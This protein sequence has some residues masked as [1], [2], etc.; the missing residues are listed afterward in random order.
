MTDS[1]AP[2]NHSQAKRLF[3]THNP[4]GANCSFLIPIFIE[5]PR[6]S[7][8]LQTLSSDVS[9]VIDFEALAA[10]PPSI[11]MTTLAVEVS[12]GQP[13]IH[14]FR[15]AQNVLIGT[16]PELMAS[17][18]KFVDEPDLIGLP[19]LRLSVV[20]FCGLEGR[21]KNASANAYDYFRLISDYSAIFWRDQTYLTSQAQ[22]ILWTYLE[23][24]NYPAND[25]ALISESVTFT[26]NRGKPK[27]SIGETAYQA[28]NQFTVGSWQSRINE[29]LKKYL[30]AF[31]IQDTS[32]LFEVVTI[33]DVQPFANV[34][35]QESLGVHFPHFL[36]PFGKAATTAAKGG[37]RKGNSNL[38]PEQLISDRVS[39][40]KAA[41]EIGEQRNFRKGS[42][43]APL[44]VMIF[45]AIDSHSLE[46]GKTFRRALPSFIEVHAVI[47]YRTRDGIPEMP[48]DTLNEWFGARPTAITVVP[49]NGFP[50]GEA[51]SKSS[52]STVLTPLLALLTDRRATK[53]DGI[54]RG[55]SLFGTAWTRKGIHNFQQVISRTIAALANPWIPL[56][57]VRSAIGELSSVGR[58][59]QTFSIEAER[60]FNATLKEQLPRHVPVE[61]TWKR[62]RFVPGANIPASYKLFAAPG[63]SIRRSPNGLSEAA[64]TILLS[65]G[66]KISASSES[67][68]SFSAALG[69]NSVQV[70]IGRQDIEH[71]KVPHVLVMPSAREQLNFLERTNG[72]Y[73]TLPLLLGDLFHLNS[74]RG[75]L[76]AAQV[77]AHLAYP[78]RSWSSKLKFFLEASLMQ[79]IKLGRSPP[80]FGG[81]KITNSSSASVS[82]LSAR[83]LAG[84]RAIVEGQ[85]LLSAGPHR[86]APR[87]KILDARFI[88]TL[89]S[90]ELL[91]EWPALSP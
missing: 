54:R 34:E 75:P 62:R 74:E 15:A 31:S 2:T 89:S 87:I 72:L 78:G 81:D 44:V 40:K 51:Q 70:V 85:L 86:A 50:L 28:L 26:V 35:S 27:L 48:V 53:P 91:V 3:G 46:L 61:T 25:R 77:L 49:D 63:P 88:A 21:R 45:D 32:L 82:I 9:I 16:K 6:N 52:W 20:D 22:R 68:R 14:A 83:K 7:L 1:S 57:S 65:Q 4:T 37:P 84:R 41:N 66:F 5:P 76:W 10:E 12:P 90:S 55:I 33:E 59:S 42:H 18:E 39:A 47:F 17:L 36:V 43:A 80:Q 67:R 30:T 38:F 24:S 79:E 23:S 71:R 58:P 64:R 60:Y 11:E 13:A 69:S 73:L 29:D 8:Y 19:I 56:T